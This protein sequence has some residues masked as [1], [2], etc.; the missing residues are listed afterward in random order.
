MNKNSSIQSF[1]LPILRD[2][3]LKSIAVK[4]FSEN[5]LRVR[6]VYLARGS[7]DSSTAVAIHESWQPFSEKESKSHTFY[8]AASFQGDVP[9]PIPMAGGPGLRTWNM[10][11]WNPG[12]GYHFNN[13]RGSKEAEG[14]PPHDLVL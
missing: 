14:T 9:Y 2:A 8:C 6:Q 1:P 3:Y 12:R 7:C 4:G 13:S 10:L 5:T 11:T